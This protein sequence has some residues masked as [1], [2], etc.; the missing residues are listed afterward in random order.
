M[1]VL[2]I[3][4]DYEVSSYGSINDFV[5]EWKLDKEFKELTGQYVEDYDNTLSDGELIVKL[6]N[7]YYKDKDHI[8]I[9]DQHEETID[10]YSIKRRK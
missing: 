3:D 10:V 7:K 4:K 6:L 2:E 1:A 8:L 5:E 9:Y